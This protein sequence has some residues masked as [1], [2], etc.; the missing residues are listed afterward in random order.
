MVKK[1]PPVKVKDARNCP[2]C[3]STNLSVRRKAPTH[4]CRRC[5]HVWNLYIGMKSEPVKPKRKPKGKE[6]VKN[7]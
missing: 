3:T 2:E 1:K 5:G 4:F 6:V 7:G